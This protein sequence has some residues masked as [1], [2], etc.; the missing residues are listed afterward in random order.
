MSAS[1]KWTFFWCARGFMS[2]SRPMRSASSSSATRSVLDRRMRSAKPTWARA[3][4]CSSSWR[5]PCFASTTVMTASSRYSPWT[6]SSMKNVCATGPGLASPVVSMSTRSNLSSPCR[7][8]FPRSPRMRTRSPRTVQ[9]RHPL[10]I[11]TICSSR[12][13]TRISLSTPVSPNSF[14]ITAIL[15]PCFSVRMRF[16]SVVFPAPRKPVRMVT[17][18]RSFSGFGTAAMRYLSAGAGT[19]ESNVWATND[20]SRSRTMN[21]SRVRRSASGHCGRRAGG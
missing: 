18:I 15:S 14:S 19:K 5:C 2:R 3:S 11:S 1:P 7:R 12:S 6:P 20:S 9:H 16:R 10:F 13:S 21:T 8:F 4:S 17:G